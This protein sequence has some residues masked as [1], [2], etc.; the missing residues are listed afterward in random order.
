MS[1]DDRISL[2]IGRLSFSMGIPLE[3]LGLSPKQT[4]IL[5]A[6]L[7]KNPPLV[8]E[9]LERERDELLRRL[10]EIITELEQRRKGPEAL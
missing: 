6:L 9:N 10:H 8:V 2:Q 5:K 7:S 4:A 3:A 1:S